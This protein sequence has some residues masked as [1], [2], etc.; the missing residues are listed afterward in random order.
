MRDLVERPRSILRGAA[1]FLLIV[2]PV[3]LVLRYA[4]YIIQKWA[5]PQPLTWLS[6]GDVTDCASCASAAW[7]ADLR[8]LLVPRP[9]PQAAL[10]WERDGAGGGG[11]PLAGCSDVDASCYNSA[12]CLLSDVER[13]VRI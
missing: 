12:A 10:P 5:D 1:R 9:R 3:L 13:A 6:E 8:A 2:L 7:P 4:F 11:A